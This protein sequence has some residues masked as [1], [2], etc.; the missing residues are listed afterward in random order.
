M[1]DKI[2]KLKE[3]YSS[4]NDIKIRKEKA[5]RIVKIIENNT[6]NLERKTCLEIGSGS[7]VMSEVFVEKFKS[8]VTIDLNDIRIAAT[9]NANFIKAFVEKLPFL[10]GKFDIIIFNHVYQYVNDKNRCLAE[11]KR[12]MKENGVCYFSTS[13]KFAIIE[14]HYSLPFLGYFS[15]SIS[16]FYL[17][18]V[19]TNYSKYDIKSD[20]YHNLVW[21]LNKY[22]IVDDITVKIIKN[23]YQY[24]FSDFPKIRYVSKLPSILLGVIN[25]TIATSW[26]FLLKTKNQ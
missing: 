12:V 4:D 17:K 23:H 2:R 3:I 10:D 14:P 18:V 15:G 22:F 25:K 6:T 16:S 26:I 9:A 1:D 20:G 24:N 11:I 8:F 19:S 5:K 7:G 13:N 21:R